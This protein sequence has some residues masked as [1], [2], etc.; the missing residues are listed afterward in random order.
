MII[1]CTFLSI[2]PELLWDPPKERDGLAFEARRELIAAV[3][4]LLRD[5][6]ANSDLVVLEF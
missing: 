4:E 2:L 1:C 3:F 6:G 5:F